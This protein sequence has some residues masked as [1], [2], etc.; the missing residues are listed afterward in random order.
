VEKKNLYSIADIMNYMGMI[1][2]MMGDLYRE[3]NLEP[4][5]ILM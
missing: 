2:D 5:N 1:R 3:R 4:I